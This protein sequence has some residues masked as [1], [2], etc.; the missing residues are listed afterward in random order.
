M[1]L[2][3]KVTILTGAA[4]GIGTSLSLMLAEHNSKLVL[5]DR[6]SV[7][8]KV[9][10][11]KLKD[12]DATYIIYDIREIKSQERIIQ[13]ALEKYNKID[14]LIN[15]AAISTS[16]YLEK[17]GDNVISEL[18]DTDLKAVIL[19]TK[20]VVKVMQKQMKGFIINFSSMAGKENSP[21]LLPYNSAKAGVISFTKS[22]AKEIAKKNL[23]IHTYSICPDSVLTNMHYKMTAQEYGVSPSDV[24][25][26]LE[27]ENPI[28]TPKSKLLSPE[29]VSKKVIDLIQGKIKIDNG[30]CLEIKK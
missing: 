29:E 9:L 8:I 17:I 18:I 2:A 13:K 30:E 3:N 6:D 14:C 4:G 7:G 26:S 10:R 22:L 21:R 28:G 12:Y 16:K 15:A 19:M 11:K 27:T 25:K 5:V 1:K 23:N 20:K 24:K